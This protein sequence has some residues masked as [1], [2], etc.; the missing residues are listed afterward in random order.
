MD[1]CTDGQMY[2]WTDVRM[3]RSTDGQM[4]GWTEVRMGIHESKHWISKVILYL[5]TMVIAIKLML[6]N[7]IKQYLKK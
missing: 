2:G 5:Q 3:D 1:R 4:Y 7:E 6:V